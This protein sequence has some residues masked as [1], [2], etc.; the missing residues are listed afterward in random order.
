MRARAP[1]QV[2]LVGR[3]GSGKSSLLL[4]LFRMVEPEAGAVSIDGVDI[5]TLGLST[6]RSAMSI[7]PQVR[8]CCVCAFCVCVC[9][10]VGACVC[11]EC[12]LQPLCVSTPP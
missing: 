4:A 7:I 12:V 11:V 3:T 5:R 10:C 8:V 1:P 6:L 2:G 9:V